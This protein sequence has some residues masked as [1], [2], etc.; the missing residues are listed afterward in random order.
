MRNLVT[1]KSK[2]TTHIANQN[3]PTTLPQIARIAVLAFLPVVSITAANV[4]MN[5]P[6][7]SNRP[8]FR[9]ATLLRRRRGMFW[10]WWPIMRRNLAALWRVSLSQR[11]TCET[12][13]SGQEAMSRQRKAVGVMLFRRIVRILVLMTTLCGPPSP[14]AAEEYS[15][16][17]LHHFE[18]NSPA[19]ILRGTNGDFYGTAHLSGT[20]L[21]GIVFR[22]TSGGVVTTLFSFSGDIGTDPGGLIEGPDGNFYGITTFGHGASGSVF[23]LTPDGIF[24]ELHIFDGADGVRPYGRLL[25][26]TDGHLYGTTTEGGAYGCGTVFRLDATTGAFELLFSFANT[27][28]CQPIGGLVELPN[29]DIYGSTSLASAAIFRISPA[30]TL[31]NLLSLSTATGYGFVYLVRAA[32]GNLY[33]TAAQGGESNAGTVFKMT[34]DGNLSTLSSFAKTNGD[35]PRGLIQAADGNFYGATE[36]GGVHG[37]GT[38]FRVTPSGELTTLADLDLENGGR[39]IGRLAEGNDRNLY[40]VAYRGG[41]FGSGTFFRLVKVPQI[42]IHRQA[43]GALVIGWDSFAGASYR[44]EYEPALTPQN[45]STLS[46][47]KA[48]DVSTSLT[49]SVASG[50]EGYFRVVLVP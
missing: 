42:R 5:P 26:A 35:F 16:Q 9:G 22:A 28:G 38:I 21:T 36:K 47:L 30:G 23:R 24:T 50:Q 10:R 32:D 15:L 19:E 46:E 1:S 25:Y 31:T 27:N 7:S 8:G 43:D 11:L 33:G 17:V 14:E 45:W 34:P 6:F 12:E 20:N 41:K 18:T 44:L 48:T 3:K 49:N 37:L 2:M 13:S 29:R 40:G 4:P 39:P